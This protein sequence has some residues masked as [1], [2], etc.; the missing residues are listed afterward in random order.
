MPST[1][2]FDIGGVLLDWNPRTL[3]RKLF[4]REAE[5]E[6]FLAEVCSV[7]WHLQQDSGR[8]AA[9]AV[10]ELSARYP[11][12]SEKIAA[13]YGRNLEMLREIGGTIEILRRLHDRGTPLFAL[14]N[15]P[16]ETFAEVREAY[17]FLQLF[18]GIV[19]SG[20]E[21]MRKPDPAFYRLL[22]ERYT[23]DP[24]DAVFIDDVPENVAAA[25]QLGISGLHFSS[26]DALHDALRRAEL[27]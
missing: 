15:W 12:Y 11:D 24:A 4:A 25:E 9:A 19:I 21:G 20:E 2:I 6:W 10:A 7:D 26:P 17:T 27:L 3:Y 1:V 13:F 22:L 8:P 16:R 5:M 14:S 23:I 18:S